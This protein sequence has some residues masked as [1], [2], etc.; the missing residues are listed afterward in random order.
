MKNVSD[1]V[2]HGID[3]T[4]A[5][6]RPGQFNRR[7]L[8]GGSV[9]LGA[10]MLPARSA[11]QQTGPSG[12]AATGE[13]AL[14]IKS[15]YAKAREV[16][17]PVCRVCPECDGI[18]CAGEM[19]GMGGVG[20]GM[21]FQHNYQ[22]LQKVRLNLRTLIDVSAG[23]R[24]PDTST[25][26]FGQ[27]LSFPAL[28]APIGRVAAEYGKGIEVVK[29]LD[30]VVGGCV[31]AGTAGA[32]GDSAAVPIEVMQARCDMVVRYNGKCIYGIRPVPN[33]TILSRLPM[34]EASKAFMM[35]IDIDAGGRFGTPE[36]NSVEPKSV[37]E[38]KELVRAAKVPLVIKG[39]MTPDEALKAAET[40]AAGIVV[41]N[42]G[43]RV[44]DHTPGTADVLPAIADKV[45][46]KM[47]IFVDG[48][49][50][51]GVDVIKYM[52]LGADAVLV[53]RHLVRAARGG[54]RDGVALF[55]RTMRDEM[56][57]GMVMTGISSVSQ[58]SRKLLV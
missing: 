45:K 12:A 11:A 36:F 29:Y 22:A 33:K 46:G 10:S 43:G 50:R 25:T 8:L 47:T 52:A 32:V 2:K 3:D 42:H 58:I 35:T 37:A 56:E 14:T 23:D 27:K 17:Y 51:H 26:I 20:S 38:L 16:L 1:F 30:A 24:R 34:I 21:S 53:G 55:M 5:T 57:M 39:I 15:V 7:D 28:A 48:C 49:V 19:P 31:D 44:L 4:H 41:S 13:T 18:A 54:G 40:G 9:L 6:D